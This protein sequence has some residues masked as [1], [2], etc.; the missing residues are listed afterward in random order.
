MTFPMDV[1][2]QL[3]ATCGAFGLSYWK[4]ISQVMTLKPF[5]MFSTSIK[6]GM[7][8]LKP[9]I[10]LIWCQGAPDAEHEVHTN[11]KLPWNI[12]AGVKHLRLH[13]KRHNIKLSAFSTL[14]KFIYV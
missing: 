13:R 2:L 14:G 10:F 9:Q 8:L 4:H 3:Q 5:Q 6:K 12:K 7:N 1:D 11:G